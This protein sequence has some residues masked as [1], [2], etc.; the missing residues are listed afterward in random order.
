MTLSSESENNRGTVYETDAIDAQILSDLLRNARHLSAPDTA[1][2]VDVTPG[3]VRNR[4]EKLESNGVIKGYEARI[5]Y[6]RLGFL[7][8]LFV[9]TILPDASGSI[10][11]EVGQLPAVIRTRIVH[12]GSHNFHVVALANCQNQITAIKN[13]LIGLDIEI[14]SISLIGSEE[15]FPFS[16]FGGTEESTHNE[17]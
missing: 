12:S 9:C 2:R 16:E 13:D 5:D 7:P 11:Q 4:I 14:E 8:I 15:T 3:T 10:S 1:A 17:S 6:Q